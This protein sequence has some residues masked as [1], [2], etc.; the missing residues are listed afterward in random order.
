MAHCLYSNNTKAYIVGGVDGSPNETVLE[1]DLDNLSV[2][3]YSLKVSLCL[4]SSHR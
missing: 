4:I 3:S 1:L 2:K